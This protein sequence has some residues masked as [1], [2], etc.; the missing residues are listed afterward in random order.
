[1]DDP[2]ALGGKRCKARKRED[3]QSGNRSKPGKAH[4]R[5][6]ETP[7]VLDSLQPHPIVDAIEV[8]SLAQQ[9]CDKIVVGKVRVKTVP[10]RQQYPQKQKA[11]EKSEAGK[12][13]T[14]PDS[15]RQAGRCAVHTLFRLYSREQ[16]TATS[17]A[18]V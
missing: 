18:K 2:D 12:L 14:E 4:Q 13:Q 6:V 7:V 1:R 16:K 11:H 9:P 3:G 10:T 5:L 17:Q 8:V 15:Y